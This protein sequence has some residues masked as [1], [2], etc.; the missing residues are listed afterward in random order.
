MHRWIDEEGEALQPSS[1]WVQKTRLLH[2]DAP[3]RG[4]GSFLEHVP[5]ALL[6]RDYGSGL[7]RDDGF[8]VK[9]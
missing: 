1:A 2:L 8:N 6:V 7:S 3:T 5:N 9:S 4:C